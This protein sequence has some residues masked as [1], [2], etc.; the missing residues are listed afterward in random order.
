M[1]AAVTNLLR[2]P[3]MWRFFGGMLPRLGL[4]LCLVLCVELAGQGASARSGLSLHAGIGDVPAGRGITANARRALT[5]VP[6]PG[7]SRPPIQP[8]AVSDTPTSTSTDPTGTDT[9]TST[10]TPTATDTGTV[11]ATRPTRARILPPAR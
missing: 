1:R 2:L 11:T 10:D 5:P 4:A 3:K 7:H 6:P 9:P 8:L